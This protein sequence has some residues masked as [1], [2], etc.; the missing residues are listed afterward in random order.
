MR[1]IP[2]SV[3]TLGSPRRLWRPSS[4]AWRNW[5]QFLAAS[6][7]QSDAR[8]AGNSP[9]SNHGTGKLCPP[10]PVQAAFP[11]HRCHEA[12]TVLADASAILD[13]PAADIPAIALPEHDELKAMLRKT[14]DYLNTTISRL[15]NFY[16]TR[17]TDYFET[18]RR[19]QHGTVLQAQAGRPRSAAGSPS[20]E[21]SYLPM[22]SAGTSSVIVSY[23]EGH[24]IE[25]LEESG[26]RLIEPAGRTPHLPR[27]IWPHPDRRPRKRHSQQDRMEPLGEGLERRERGLSVSG[28]QANQYMVLVAAPRGNRAD[29][30]RFPRRTCHRSRRWQYCSR[31]VIADFYPPLE[32]VKSSILVEYASV[33]IGA[34]RTS[35][36][37]RAS[38]LAKMPV[39]A[40]R[41]SSCPIKPS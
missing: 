28:S 37:S 7:G 16:A 29:L 3:V 2:F 36:Q 38:P 8:V 12:F 34:R 24:E 25:G 19:T 33:S 15:P 26:R 20:V 17:K 11:G 23:R 5:E 6:H 18:P 13:L 35:V 14:V 31:Y 1:R 9:V 22:H 39:K 32:Q 27:R 4:S 10:R 30:P 21:S 41:T 40:S